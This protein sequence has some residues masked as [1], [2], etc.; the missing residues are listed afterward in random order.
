ML[1][2]ARIFF[3]SPPGERTLFKERKPKTNE[4]GA[5]VH[6]CPEL[7][8]VLFAL[9]VLSSARIF[10][11]SP[12]GERTLFKERKPKTTKPAQVSTCARSSKRFYSVI[13]D[14]FGTD[15]LSI[16]SGRLISI[17]VEKARTNEAG[18]SVHLC[19]EFKEVL[20]RYS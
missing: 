8:E 11:L 15:F 3:L 17:Q 19:P 5:S 14:V 18:A 12:P 2:P 7:K 13:L 1:S 20:F 6:L 16:A 4:D 9:F 10:F